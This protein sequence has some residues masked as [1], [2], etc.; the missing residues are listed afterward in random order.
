MPSP[1]ALHRLHPLTHVR[2]PFSGRPWTVL[3]VATDVAM[4]WIA[5]AAAIALGPAGAPP[6][7]SWLLGA[8]FA[9]VVLVHMSLRGAYDGRSD[10]LPGLDVVRS[11]FQASAVGAVGALAAASVIGTS[12]ALTVML[13]TAA[14]L[15][16][17]LVGAGRLTLLGA[18]RHARVE[19]RSVRPTLIVGAGRV[20]ADLERRLLADP[21]LGLR[22]VGFLD[23][24][25]APG[26]WEA[27]PVN[28]V[29]GAPRELAA[30]ARRTQAQQVVIAFSS[31]R[32]Q[33]VLPVVRAAQALGLE[34]SVVPRMFEET[35][36]RQQVM[37]Q[38]GT[39]DGAGTGGLVLCDLRARQPHA[40]PFAV[41]HV[42]GR[43]IALAI[44]IAVAPV[45]LTAAAAVRLTSAGPVLFRQRRVGRDGQVFEILK[46]RTMRVPAQPSGAGERS[47]VAVGTGPGG[48]EGEDRRTRVGCLLRRSSLDELPQLFNVVMGHMSLVGP[49]PERPE[50]VA[51]FGQQVRG[52]DDRHRVKSGMTGWA[53]VHGLRG[54]T[55]IADRI[56][57]D[58]WYVTNWSLWLDLKI[59]L[60]TP[61][62]VLRSRAE[63]ATGAAEGSSKGATVLALRRPRSPQAFPDVSSR[64]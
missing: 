60:M 46:L 35:A 49:R 54:G 39:P 57:M 43:L 23:E 38:I 45:L 2:D 13:V 1:R 55:S 36:S 16:A 33:E 40:W 5:V 28:P 18:R 61:L 15:G 42:T 48:V 51:L 25:P 24:A 10:R 26:F 14:G 59:L 29:L 63:Q 32:D 3:T 21:A 50:F 19:G 37:T 64:G 12:P 27:G 8:V 17:V 58:N 7:G 41:K 31:A 22:P 53:Q 56:E 6:P 4:L 9:L 20:G 34:V 52:Y 11:I 30:V 44:A 62:E 47:L